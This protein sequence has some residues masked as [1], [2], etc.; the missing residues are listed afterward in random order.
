MK[1][2]FPDRPLAAVA[3]LAQR[4]QQGMD[5]ESAIR[6]MARELGFSDEEIEQ[7]RLEAFGG[8]A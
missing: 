2:L 7:E 3:R 1:H 4:I 6:M 5:Q 8:Q